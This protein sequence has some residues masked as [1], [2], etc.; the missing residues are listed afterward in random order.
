M[1]VDAG[2]VVSTAAVDD[3][4]AERWARILDPHLWSII[5]GGPT[6]LDLRTIEHAR[7]GSIRRARRAIALAGEQPA[8]QTVRA[9]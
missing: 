7:V 1:S 9:P 6:Q 2:I 3:T 8:A 4:E 5:D